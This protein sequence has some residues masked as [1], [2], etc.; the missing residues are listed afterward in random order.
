MSSEEWREHERL[1][2]DEKQKEQAEKKARKAAREVKKLEA[3]KK[4][5]EKL[6]MKEQKIAAA[7]KVAEA[8]L[9]QSH[10]NQNKTQKRIR[11]GTNG[12]KC[13]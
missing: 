4:A 3:A 7:K 11:K 10:K 5:V 9:S 2:I 12:Q 1:K 8:K 6:A 13:N